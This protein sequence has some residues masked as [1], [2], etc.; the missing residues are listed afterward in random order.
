MASLTVERVI[1]APVEVVF[2][3]WTE[4]DHIREWFRVEDSWQCQS[5]EMNLAVDGVYHLAMRSPEGNVFSV[6]GV[7]RAIDAPRSLSYTWT[8]DGED[9]FGETLVTVVFE[10]LGSATR[11]RLSHEQFITDEQAVAHEGGWN[12]CINQLER[13]ALRAPAV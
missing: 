5:S 11:I 13:L 4:P 7:F 1:D 2:A 12:R 10:P 6:R 3:F 8:V 9:D